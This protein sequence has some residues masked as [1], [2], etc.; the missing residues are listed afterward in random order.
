MKVS[1]GQTLVEEAQNGTMAP[2]YDSPQ[3]PVEVSDDEAEHEHDDDDDDDNTQTSTPRPRLSGKRNESFLEKMFARKSPEEVRESANDAMYKR[4]GP[5]E[6]LTYGMVQRYWQSQR[7]DGHWHTLYQ[8]QP[9]KF[10]K[11]MKKGYMEPIPTT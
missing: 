10:I 6:S 7:I 2:P 11:Y 4:W 8:T 1:L 5:S 9:R 3:R